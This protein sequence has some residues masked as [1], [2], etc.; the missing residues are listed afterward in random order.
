[1]KKVYII[2]YPK[3][4]LGDDLFINMLVNRYKNVEFYSKNM[5]MESTA[6][7]QNKNLHFIDYSLDDLLTLDI[8][9][10]D[11]LVYIGSSIFKEYDG[12]IERVQKLKDLAIRCK[13]LSIPFYCISSYLGQGQTEESLKLIY[14]L[15]AESTDVCLRD[16]ISFEQFRSIDTVRYA[17]D[18]IFSYKLEDVKKE[19]NTIGI[20]VIN[21]KFREKMQKYESKYLEVLTKSIKKYI[22]KG[23]KVKLFNFC[24]YEGD[25]DSSNLIVNNLSIAE[26]KFV[27]IITY[28]GNI[29]DFLKKYSK[30]EYMICSRFHS[31]IL[32]Y[33]LGQKIYVLSYSSKITNVIDDLNLIDTYY[34]LNS[35]NNVEDYINLQ[36]FN[37]VNFDKTI[38]DEAESQFKSLDILLQ[39]NEPDENITVIIPARNEEKTI[40]KVVKLVQKCKLVNQII[41]VDNN[42]IDNT[43][44][45]AQ[46]V[47]A[48]VVHCSIPGKGYAMEAG[49]KHSINDIVVYI[50]ADISN[51]SKDLIIKLAEP[52]LYKKADFVKSRFD[53]AGGRVTELVAK[54]LL[55][56]LFP[57][58]HKFSQ[59]LSGM[60]AG[61]RSIF[62]QIIFEKDYGVDIGIL[63]DMVNINARIKEVHIGTIK[64]ASQQWQSLEKMSREVIQAIIKRANY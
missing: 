63:L 24:D 9:D 48:Y 49:L 31:L 43:A 22:E 27:E 57:D 42:S 58:I 53:R 50:D 45:L 21:Y 12:G 37:D 18:A 52:L 33:I 10:F 55:D 56:I 30:V 6:Y 2:A 16:K 44:K 35:L 5:Q 15:F 14:D 38:L 4:N 40:Q 46:S 41:V 3:M 34:N 13:T 51:Y 26:K 47:G 8:T 20:S 29:K 25:T 28:N 7:K 11:A 36:D 32:S 54:P 17:P 19:P 59:P 1:M 23:F 39:Q 60:I 61:R 64:N 62:E